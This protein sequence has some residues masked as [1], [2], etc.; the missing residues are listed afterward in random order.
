MSEILQTFDFREG[1]CPVCGADDPKIL[2][3]RGG[4]AHQ[5]GLGVRTPIVRCLHCSHQYP[6]PMPF[7][8]VGM[9]ELYGE[10]EEYFQRHDL[11]QKKN[12]GLSVMAEIERRSGRK[13]K[14]LD[15]GCGR[16]ELLWAARESGWEFEGIDTSAKFLEFGR[17]ELGVEGR[18]GTPEDAAFPADSFDAVVMGGL[19]EHLYDPTSTLREIFRILRPGGWLYLDAPNED[20]LYM[21]VGNAYMK[22]LGRD[23]VVVLAPTF[24]PYHVQGFNPRSIQTLL[25]LNNFQM[26]DFRMFGDISPQ[27]GS[28]TLRKSTEYIAGRLINWFGKKIGQGMYMEMWAQ[29]AG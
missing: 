10:A 21:R 28:P 14:L 7:P 16:G 19:I 4:N 5:S 8:K 29:K 6:N 26:R 18:L 2:G 17:C 12:A 3:Y 25:A 20:G 27:T 9:T 23:W 1:N 13:G 15:I 22:A 24:S 11:A